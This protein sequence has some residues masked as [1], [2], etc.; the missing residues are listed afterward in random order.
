MAL[1]RDVLPLAMD[2]VHE[3]R[4]VLLAMAEQSLVDAGAVNKGDLIVLTVGEPVGQPGGTNT[5]KIVRVTA[6]A[7]E[8]FASGA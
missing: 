4:D 5:M 3:D 7:G 6:V 1:Y 8:G 2:R